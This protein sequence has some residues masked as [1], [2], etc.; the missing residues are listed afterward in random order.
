M[1]T[2]SQAS[3]LLV[4]SERVYGALLILYPADFCYEYAQ[5]MLQVF[6]D[7]GRDAYR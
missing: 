2:H 1:K 5:H 6:R 4:L 3:K 7:I